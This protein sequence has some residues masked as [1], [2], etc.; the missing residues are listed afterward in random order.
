MLPEFPKAR[1]KM[2]DLWNTAFFNG[3]NGCDPFLSQIP[4]RVQKEGDAAHTGG[5]E[6]DY[7]LCSVN[8]SFPARDAQGMSEEE[9]LG[10]P[11]RL[12]TQMAGEQAKIVFDKLKTP[13]PHGMPLEWKIGELQFDQVLAIWEKMEVNFGSD[14]MPQWPSIVLQPEARAELLEKLQKWHN[15]PECR[16]KW[17][18][19]VLRK[20]K[21][22]DEREAHRRLVD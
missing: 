4:V 7:K 14:G 22:F 19:L 18:D 17:E 10:A 15:D 8:F 6:M 1:R 13:S 12:G 3:M 5:G 16:K 11:F 21:E 20:R 2:L 9:F